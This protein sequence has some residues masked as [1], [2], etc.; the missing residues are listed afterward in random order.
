MSNDKVR[1]EFEAAYREEWVRQRDGADIT[2][3]DEAVLI[4]DDGVYRIGPIQGMWWSWQA[5][6]KALVVELPPKGP[7][8]DPEL[9][10]NAWHNTRNNTIEACR[11]AIEAAGVRVKP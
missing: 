9:P 10:G 6:R 3:F 4:K 2:L 5:S 11:R 7:S 8:A 1:A